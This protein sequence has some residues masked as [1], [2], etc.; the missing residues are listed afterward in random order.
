M[1]QGIDGRI[2]INKSTEY[3]KQAADQMNNVQQGQDFIN[4]MEKARISQSD[5]SVTETE[6]T[7]DERIQREKNGGGQPD[8][9][10]SEQESSEE[11]E[12]DREETS[13]IKSGPT[14][15]GDSIDINV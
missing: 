4:E 7:Q 1:I 2:M 13:D 12:V 10:D 14:G 6:R 9:A 5:R 3:A 8:E 15:L 11:E